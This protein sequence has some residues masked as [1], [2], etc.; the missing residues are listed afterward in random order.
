MDTHVAIS[1][2]PQVFAPG[3]YPGLDEETYHASAG[4]SVSKLKVFAKAPA[5]A[6]WGTNI[7]TE[8]LKFGRLAHCAILEPHELERRF[9]VSQLE[10]FDPRSSAYKDQL[11]KAGGREI[12]KQEDADNARWM[13]DAIYA[14]SPARELLT[15]G[16]LAVE[17]SMYW[18]DPETGLLCRGRCDATRL[19]APIF[20][21]LKTVED[22]SKDAFSRAVHEYKYH[23]QDATYRDGSPVAGGPAVEAFVF[24]AVE[25]VRPWLVGCYEV[26]A[27]ALRLGREKVGFYLEQWKICEELDSWPGYSNQIE[28]ISLPS[29]AFAG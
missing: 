6:R 4:V 5:K 11:F 10:R 20:L 21:D 25:K 16:P 24:M 13:R 8:A 18:K 7:E 9:F 26:D 19:D 3:I 12:V 17:Q 15:T 14:Q 22:A 27:D 29:Y 23:W 2:T 1:K 28:S